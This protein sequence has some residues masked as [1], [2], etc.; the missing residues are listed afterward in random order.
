LPERSGT[1]IGTREDVVDEATDRE[2]T[3]TWRWL[4]WPA[5]AVSFVLFALPQ[6]FF[7]LMSFHRNLGF[8]RL[9]TTFTTANYVRIATDPLYLS[10]LG[11]T[12]YLSV[13]VTLIALVLAFP[14]AYVL[15]R[16]PPRWA[17]PL[18]SGLLISSFVTVVIRVLGL[19]VILS[20]NGL[21]NSLLRLL[22]VRA[23]VQFLSNRTGVLIGLLH[24]TLPLLVLLL[25]SVIQ[26]IP[27]SLEHA[28]EIHGASRLR[29][30]RRLVIPLAMPGVVAGAL[31][32][33][34]MSMGAFTSAVLLGG[35]RVLTLPVLIQRKIVA[36]VDYPLGSALS[37]TLLVVVFVLNV[38][39]ASFLLR[40]RR[41]ARALA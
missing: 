3:G 24:Y 13:A 22:G 23:P 17:S 11:L 39:C 27:V 34:N 10:S 21:V 29:V 35:G 32:A 41:R 36:D 12:L 8:G 25:F 18:I 19:V 6:L 5:L 2:R 40:G 4:L 30:L 33:F 1:V 31:I 38:A 20:E 7:I 16:V 9:S 15:A 14:T 26:T 28:A 37:T